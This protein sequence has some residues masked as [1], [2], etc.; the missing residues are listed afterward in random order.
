MERRVGVV[1]RECRDAVP[2]CTHVPGPRKATAHLVCVNE[3]AGEAQLVPR[4]GVVARV[5]REQNKAPA[6]RV[7][8]EHHQGASRVPGREYE[9]YCAV[10]KEVTS[11]AKRGIIYWREVHGFD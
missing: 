1:R 4:G 10:T 9:P 8:R 5:A 3:R 2:T 7:A 11:L 6:R